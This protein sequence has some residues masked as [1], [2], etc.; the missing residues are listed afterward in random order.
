MEACL[1]HFIAEM[2]DEVWKLMELHAS[3]SH[4]EDPS[5]WRDE[6]RAYLKTLI[7]SD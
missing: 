2:E 5:A 4:D 1:G 3:V 7:K 6:D